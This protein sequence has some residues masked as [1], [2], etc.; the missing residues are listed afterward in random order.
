MGESLAS[1]LESAAKTLSYAAIAALVGACAVRWILAPTLANTHT[2]GRFQSLLSQLARV[3]AIAAG[4]TLGAAVLRLWSHTAVAFGLPD[5]FAWDNLRVIGAESRWGSGWRI[6]AAAAVAATVAGWWVV[7][8]PLRRWVLITVLALG[9]VGAVPLLGHG[10]IDP[11]RMATHAAHVL[12]A[13]VWL[14]SLAAVV[15]ATRGASHLRADLLRRF[16]RLA[17]PGAALLAVSGLSLSWQYVGAFDNLTRTAYGQT[18][19]VK[20]LLVGGV[21]ACGFLNWRSYRVV[22]V[23]DERAGSPASLTPGAPLVWAELMLAG[24]VVLAT[25]VLTELEHP[26]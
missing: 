24:L 1:V 5:A 13:G 11:A 15:L 9:A 22:S 25:S 20:L 18:L 16:S 23:P 21:L 8:D 12:G 7:A 19:L 14:G 6:Q 10:A 4:A 26:E 17:L 2:S 3:G